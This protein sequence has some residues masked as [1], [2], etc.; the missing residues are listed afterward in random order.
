MVREKRWR[1][2]CWLEK[3]L[4][5]KARHS[6]K[7]STFQKTSNR[8]KLAALK[9]VIFYTKFA[10]KYCWICRPG[11]ACGWLLS[12][13]WCSSWKTNGQ[14]NTQLLRKTERNSWAASCTGS[15]R[16][17]GAPALENL[18]KQTKRESEWW[19]QTEVE[20]SHGAYWQPSSDVPW[21]T[22][23]RCRPSRSQTTVEQP[24]TGTCCWSNDCSD[25][26]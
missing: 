19:K 17:Y 24:A 23:D 16:H 20:Y 10:S 26:T 15:G 5:V 25:V 3:S 6:S 9:F 2:R 22:Y 1:L 21:R 18:R 12:S 8:W 11:S 4:S 7:A 13:V 14:R